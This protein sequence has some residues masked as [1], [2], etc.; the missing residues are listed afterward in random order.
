MHASKKILKWSCVSEAFDVKLVNC[1]NYFKSIGK[2]VVSYVK[3]QTCDKLIS[4]FIENKI[5]S[6]NSLLNKYSEIS[7][8]LFKM[9]VSE[10]WVNFQG[11]FSATLKLGYMKH[12]KR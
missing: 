3:S 8:F 4:F 2:A 1:C 7:H 12:E 6:G 11:Q 10:L 9:P 5:V